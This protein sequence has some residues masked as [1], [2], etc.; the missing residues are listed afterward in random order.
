MLSRPKLPEIDNVRALAIIAVLLI[1][2]TSNATLLPLGTASQA[3]FFILNKISL[4]TVPLFIWIS[5]LVLFYTYFDR[6]EP[7]MAIA[8]WTKRVRKILI[9]YV[10][11]SLF[12][13]LF[14]QFMFHGEI[15]VDPV[16][17]IKLLVSGN[18]SYH[19]Y[20]MIIIVQFYLLFPLLMTAAKRFPRFRQSLIPLGIILQ[21]SGYGFHHWV[22]PIPEYTSLF[23]SYLVLF[24]CGAFVGIHYSAAV[25]WSNRYRS[26]LWS[27]ALIAGASYASMLLLHQYSLI[28]LENTWYELA[29]LLYCLA[30]PLCVLQWA[31]RLVFMSSSLSRLM[32]S[33]G[34]ASFGIYLLHPALLTLWDR[35]A[36]EQGRLL[37]YDLH[38]ICSV[39]IGLFGS[40]LL[41]RLSTS[42]INKKNLRR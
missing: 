1:H 28:S 41:V 25:S 19:L 20:Y 4:F 15:H 7:G 2:G 31:R 22:H 38:T 10:G 36:P 6:W 5:G 12:Y 27:I 34:A 40:W 9:P 30:I 8:F 35:L 13:Y 42:L 26:W 21:V 33:L 16:Y 24:A 11:W 32:S 18:A 39:V 17:F 23:I 29:L 3:L 14:N 37:L